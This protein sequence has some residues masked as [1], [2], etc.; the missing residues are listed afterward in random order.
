VSPDWALMR[1]ILALLADDDGL[2]DAEIAKRLGRPVDEV[3]RAARV[4]YRQRRTDFCQGF[5]VLTPH[6]GE[7]RR[8]A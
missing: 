8:S 4:L 3:Q 5:I 7:G 2:A 6:V 1:R